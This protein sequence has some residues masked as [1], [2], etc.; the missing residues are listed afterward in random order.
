MG[1]ASGFNLGSK[2]FVSLRFLFKLLRFA[3]SLEVITGRKFCQE[4]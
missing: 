4:V 3:G 2:D 1:L